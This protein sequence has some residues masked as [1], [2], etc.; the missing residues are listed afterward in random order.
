[1]IVAVLEVVV[2]NDVLE[3]KVLLGFQLAVDERAD[4]VHVVAEL[5][6]GNEVQVA[7]LI[8]PFLEHVGALHDQHRDQSG[9]HPAREVLI[10][11][12]LF[13]KVNGSDQIFVDE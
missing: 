3:A 5:P 12:V 6:V 7:R 11:A 13:Q 4:P 8:F 10:R 9:A 2:E 1:M